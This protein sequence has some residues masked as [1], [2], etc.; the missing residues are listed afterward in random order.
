MTGLVGVMLILTFVLLA[1]G[2]R[3]GHFSGVSV[4]M[5]QIRNAT[6]MPDDVE[7][8]DVILVTVTREGHVYFGIERI[9]V[10]DLL[11]KLRDQMEGRT[12][13]RKVYIKADANADYG[14][15]SRV[16]EI[17]RQAGVQNIAFLTEAQRRTGKQ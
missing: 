15:V 3:H 14:T 7:R 11:T 17:V 9:V 10:D 6:E 4:D 2:L 8:E 13:E 16:V 1:E 5:A 12:G